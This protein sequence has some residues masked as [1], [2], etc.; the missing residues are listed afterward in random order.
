MSNKRAF[1]S[2][3]AAVFGV[4]IAMGVV[5]EIVENR[6]IRHL[7]NDIIVVDGIIVKKSVTKSVTKSSKK[8][9]KKNEKEGS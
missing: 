5:A 7:N 3:I 6:V 1:L 8:T 4:Y 2:G 9:Q